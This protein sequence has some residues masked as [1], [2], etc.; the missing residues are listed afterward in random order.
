[1]STSAN[2]LSN[3]ADGPYASARKMEV[4]DVEVL[5]HLGLDA[6]RLVKLRDGLE[7]AVQVAGEAIRAVTRRNRIRVGHKHGEGPVTEADYAA[8]AVLHRELT[9]LLPEA[10]WLSEESTQ[11]RPLIHGEPTWVVDP[12]DGTREFLR[13]LTEY[14]VSVGLF[15]ADRLVLGAVYIPGEDRLLSGL[16]TP[17]H[18]EARLDGQPLDTL[19]TDS[20]VARVVV[21]RHDYEWRNLHYRIPYEVYPCGSAAVKLTH[22]ADGQADVY[23]STGPRSVWD[24]AGGLAI[25]RAVGGEL[26]LF[27][28]SPLELSPQQHRVPPYAAGEPGACRSLLRRLGARF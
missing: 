16:I 17:G 19:T 4:V 5:A 2:G 9:A 14:G 12:L 7:V 18:R 15:V 10:H 21:S 3:K 27:N 22:A 13:G 1:M 26:V 28:G 24:V 23:L 25:L 6:A 20:S 8:D 11:D